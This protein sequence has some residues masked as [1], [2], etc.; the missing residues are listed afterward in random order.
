MTIRRLAA[1]GAAASL[2]FTL[3]ACGGDPTDG[4]GVT[5]GS[6][7]FA[8]NEIIAEVYA[9]ALEAEGID[10]N[11]QFQ[12]GSREVYLQ[13]LESG[14]VDIIPEYTGNLLSFYDPE[15][16]AATPEEVEDALDDVLPDELD[17]LEPA[18]AENKD[19]LNVTR[20]FAE[21]NGVTSIADLATLDSVRL[22]ANPEFEQRPYGLPGLEAV[23]GLTNIVFESNSD[24]GGPD[25]LKTL[26]D[27]RAD[28]ADI[29]TTTPS[30]VE[31]D[32]VTLEDPEGLILSQ[33]V[34]PLI[35]D[36][37]D[38]DR[39]EDVLDRIS[40]QLKTEDLLEFNI[41]NSGDEKAAPATIA[42]E[43]LESKNLI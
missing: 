36:S 37:V 27:G 11:R 7:A 15:T 29:Y 21:T 6:A 14:E 12:I 32:L 10:V 24:Y 9:Q 28:V 25:T 13:A 41:R 39:I 22:V 16:T 43:W 5:I 42:K 18:D 23:Y 35:R 40:A 17:I 31:N 19:S 38:D 8:E 26:L 20:E 33:N 34:V 30:I 3:S 4:D 2:A 1:I